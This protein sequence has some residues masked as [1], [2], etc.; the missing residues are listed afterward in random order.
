MLQDVKDPTE[1]QCRTLALD[2]VEQKTEV[3]AVRH[4]QQMHVEVRY[5]HVSDVI[6]PTKACLNFVQILHLQVFLPKVRVDGCQ[7]DATSY[8]VDSLL[9]PG[10]RRT[11]QLTRLSDPPEGGMNLF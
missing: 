11:T 2:V 5:V 3:Q 8:L 6:P 7:I 9:L 1:K 10:R 4:D